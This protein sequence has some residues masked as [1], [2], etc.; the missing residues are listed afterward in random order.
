MLEK[1]YHYI[2]LHQIP[3][4]PL[5]KD[6]LYQKMTFIISPVSRTSLNF[7]VFNKKKGV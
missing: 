4:H 6:V 1:K 5:D 3:Y 2:H 7:D